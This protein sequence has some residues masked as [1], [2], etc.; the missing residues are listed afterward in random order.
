MQPSCGRWGGRGGKRGVCRRLCR[1][2][3]GGD[4]DKSWM[5]AEADVRCSRCLGNKVCHHFEPSA[6]QKAL[7]VLS[8]FNL[9][10]KLHR[11]LF[12]DW[13]KLS[14]AKR[15]IQTLPLGEP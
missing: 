2:S 11:L 6:K 4:D 1:S 3:R 10:I 5:E 13:Q 7:L 15:K 9:C 14:L 12:T 8:F